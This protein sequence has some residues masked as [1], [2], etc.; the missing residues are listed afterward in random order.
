VEAATKLVHAHG[1]QVPCRAPP[2]EKPARIL[3]EDETGD[4]QN[5]AIAKSLYG[6]SQSLR[7]SAANVSRYFLKPPRDLEDALRSHLRGDRNAPRD[8]RIRNRH[9][10][11]EDGPWFS[12]TALSTA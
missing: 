3:M 7:F 11:R 2:R 8:W 1:C 5:A 9:S 12:S 10:A 6:R 4:F